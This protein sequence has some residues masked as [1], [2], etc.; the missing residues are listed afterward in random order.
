MEK[1]SC[2]IGKIRKGLTMDNINWDEWQKSE[3]DLNI[4]NPQIDWGD[5]Q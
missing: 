1:A 5:E 2:S 4:R 3:D